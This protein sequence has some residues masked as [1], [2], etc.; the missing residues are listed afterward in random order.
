M[1]INMS[2]SV[3]VTAGGSGTRLGG[4]VPKQFQMLGDRPVLAHTLGVFD[5]LDIREIVVAVPGGYIDHTWE[6][7]RSHGFS[8]VRG[9]VSGGVNRA[10]SVLT[11]LKQLPRDTGIVLIHDGVRPFVSKEL[12][13]AV[14]KATYECSAAVAGTV[15]TDT[16][17]EVDSHGQ[18]VSTPDRQRFWRV[19]TPQ[20]FT[21][22][23]IMDA[24]A[25][26][27]KDGILSYV[28]DD[29]TL[30][31]RLDVPVMMVEGSSDNIKITT[32]EDLILSELLLENHR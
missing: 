14:A 11:A 24:Y 23:L 30:V 18:V 10:E 3:I 28:T 2:I 5:S 31:E 26:G 22:K 6:I 17:K 25:Q 7:V 8:K 1:V 4:E 20:G 9:I 16:L 13:K 15:L 32:R 29:S 21:Y 12:I 27:E 19:Q